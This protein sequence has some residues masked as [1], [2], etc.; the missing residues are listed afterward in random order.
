[1]ASIDPDQ[2]P[3]PTVDED[4]DPGNAA[5]GPDAVETEQLLPPLPRE[6]PLNAQMEDE[7]MPEEVL[8]PEGHDREADLDDP[9]K[10]PPG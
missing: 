1:M 2:I 5:G 10:E 9:S 4:P 8:Q 3:E 7:E 6:E